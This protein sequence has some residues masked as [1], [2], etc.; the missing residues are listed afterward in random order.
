MGL[1][2]RNLALFPGWQLGRQPQ[3][4]R[5]ERRDFLGA[6]ASVEH[7]KLGELE[8]DV[9]TWLTAEWW[10]Q[11]AP[12]DGIT[13]FTWYRLGQD[14]WGAGARSGWSPTGRHRELMQQAVSN[15]MGA[16]LTLSGY[17]VHAQRSAPALFSDVHLLR[18]VVRPRQRGASADPVF[19]GGLRD[20]TVEV[21]FEEWLVAQLLGEY[22]LLLDW[23]VQRQLTGAAK[24][25]WYYLGGLGPSF[26]PTAWPQESALAIELSPT[27]LAGW[28]F[29]AARP[30]DQRAKVARAGQRIV[31]ID[32][33][34]SAI[35]VEKLPESRSTY[36]LRA[37][38]H[39]NNEAT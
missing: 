37:V 38:R 4:T 36:Q 23:H 30:A 29:T 1:L 32:P 28:G 26:Q 25:L 17:D 2:E 15:L 14:L 31:A 35:S 3:R 27:V 11:G 34:Y 21:R 5:I 18:S 12:R 22:A 7:A 8:L 16:V 10:E 20:D 39:Q 24:R 6:I 19:E 9:L 13:R 33:R